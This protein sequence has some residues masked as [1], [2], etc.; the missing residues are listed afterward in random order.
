MAEL[1][2]YK[3]QKGKYILKWLYVKKQIYIYKKR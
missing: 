3:K 1:Y 2:E